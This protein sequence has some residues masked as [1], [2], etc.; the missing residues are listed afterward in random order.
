MSDKHLERFMVWFE[1]AMEREPRLMKDRTMI[2][3]LWQQFGDLMCP[4]TLQPTDRRVKHE[5]TTKG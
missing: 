4:V 5:T 2:R 1:A 3:L